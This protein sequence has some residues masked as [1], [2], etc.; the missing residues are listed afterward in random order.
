MWIHESVKKSR[1]LKDQYQMSGVSVFIKDALPEEVD[2]E[3]VFNYVSSRVPLFLTSNIDMIYVG[4]FPEFEERQI[5]AFFENDAIYVTNQQDDE[6]DMIED[7]IHEMSHAVEQR[8]GDLIYGDSA[9]EREFRAKRERLEVRLKKHYKTPPSFA[10]NLEYDKGVDN[11]LYAEV[12]YD[13]LRQLIVGIF[14]TA[15]SVTSVSEYWAI[16]YEELFLGDRDRLKRMCPVLYNKLIITMKE[17][18]V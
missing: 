10:I 6:M 18:E 1:K 13:N 14:P 16:G 5:N 7:I 12:G 11:F 4:Q 17:S 15:Y 8:L 3:F 9:L 2:A